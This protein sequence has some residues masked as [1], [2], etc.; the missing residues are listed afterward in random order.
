MHVWSA[1]GIFLLGTGAGAVTTAAYYSAQIRELSRLI[2]SASAQ[3]AQEEDS[4]E[5]KGDEKR[6]SA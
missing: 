1:L 4:A 2:A 3:N 5:T 6:K